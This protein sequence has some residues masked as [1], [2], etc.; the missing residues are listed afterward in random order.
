MAPTRSSRSS[1][2]TNIPVT[3]STTTN[4][5]N[6]SR[7]TSNVEVLQTTTKTKLPWNATSISATPRGTPATKPIWGTSSKL[8]N[9]IDNKTMANS[10]TSKVVVNNNI[11][12][13]DLKRNETNSRDISPPMTPGNGLGIQMEGRNSGTVTEKGLE[14][15]LKSTIIDFG[16]EKY[17]PSREPIK[18]SYAS[19]SFLESS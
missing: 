2:N 16:T 19:F 1:A 11:V 5:A 4:N 17:E 13:K 7:K 12:N 8:S 18:V 6:R 10:K 15:L 3:P 9:V 14:D